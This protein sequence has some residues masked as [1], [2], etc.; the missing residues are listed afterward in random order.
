MHGLTPSFF[1]RQVIP[2]LLVRPHPVRLVM[3]LHQDLLYLKQAQLYR[4]L[5]YYYV[6]ITEAVYK[7][8]GIQ[9]T[10]T[11]DT[12]ANVALQTWKK[13][14]LKRNSCDL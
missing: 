4:Y 12:V 7:N 14:T 2:Y 3:L 9:F 10:H 13:E 6:K 11:C 1:P 5:R 8:L